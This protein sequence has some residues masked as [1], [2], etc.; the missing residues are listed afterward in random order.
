MTTAESSL[1][2]REI[3]DGRRVK[4][5]RPGS[6][7]AWSS[8]PVTMPTAERPRA[9]TQGE[10]TGAMPRGMSERPAGRTMPR[11]VREVCQR[12]TCDITWRLREPHRHRRPRREPAANRTWR[13][14]DDV[15]AQWLEL[16]SKSLR[17]RLH[18][19]FRGGVV[20]CARHALKCHERAHQDDASAFAIDEAPTERVAERGHRS[21]VDID[22]PQFFIEPPIHERTRRP[23]ACRCDEKAHVPV[24]GSSDEFV[25]TWPCREVDGHRL[26]LNVVGAG[27]PV[28]RL[29]RGGRCVALRGRD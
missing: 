22:H 14:R 3:I 28:R 7:A 5:H 15:D 25:D 6:R 27:Q 1:P 2:R 19:G 10:T 21:T 8:R 29:R 11:V 24:T 12:R 23:K 20:R 9:P 18:V 16:Q 26:D 13:R 4:T 17:K